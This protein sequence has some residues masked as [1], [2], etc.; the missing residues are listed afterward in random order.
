MNVR[1]LILSLVI[2]VAA[3]KWANE[4]GMLKTDPED[5]TGSI[6]DDIPNGLDDMQ[7][8]LTDEFS[9]INE[10]QAAANLAA[11]LWVIRVSE[12]TSANDGYR[13]LF[14]YTPANGKTFNSYEDHPKIF[15]PYTD[16]SGKVIKTSAA[17]A[18]QITATTYNALKQKYGFVGFDPDTQDAMAVQLIAEKSALNDVKAGRFDMALNKLRKIWASLPNSGVNQPTRTRDYLASAYQEAGGVF[19]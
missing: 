7:N 18:Y 2:L 4:N 13:A 6:L 1:D 5:Q 10:T 17:G 3:I 9:A 11:F 8:K 14:G 15:F 19:A 16:L 12:G